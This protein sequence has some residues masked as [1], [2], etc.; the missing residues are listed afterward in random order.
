MRGGRW[1]RPAVGCNPEKLMNIG[2]CGNPVKKQG[3]L[4]SNMNKAFVDAALAALECDNSL[5][6]SSPGF[7]SRRRQNGKKRRSERQS[8]DESP[9]S[10]ALRASHH[11]YSSMMSRFL[12]R[13]FYQLFGIAPLEIGG[14]SRGK[15][16]KTTPR[17]TIHCK[18]PFVKADKYF[19]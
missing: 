6:L 1:K 15:N 19:F 17:R 14:L 9:H 12:Q 7:N 3:V 8:G 5:S 13:V 11:T 16:R 4:L 2:G 18:Y 10:K